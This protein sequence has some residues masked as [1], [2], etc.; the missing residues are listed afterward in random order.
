MTII[1]AKRTNERPDS[2]HSGIPNR[3]LTEGEYRAFTNEQRKLIRDCGL[4]EVATD[5]EIAKLAKAE[6][7]APKEED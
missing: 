3:D 2:Y 4:W 1:R 7:S 5:K 6:R